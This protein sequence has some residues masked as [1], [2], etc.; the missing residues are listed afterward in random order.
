MLSPCNIPPSPQ[1]T[2]INIAPGGKEEMITG[3]APVSQSRVTESSLGTKRLQSDNCHSPCLWLISFCK[4][5]L[6]TFE[7]AFTTKQL[8]AST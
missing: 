7:L 6:C 8:Y 1:L 5:L 2:E 3:P 4:H